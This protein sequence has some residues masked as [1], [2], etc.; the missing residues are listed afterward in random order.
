M[1][2][3]PKLLK[4]RQTHSRIFAIIVVALVLFCKPMIGYRSFWYQAMVWIGYAMVLVGAF[5]RVYC[6]VFIGGRKNDGIVRNGPF[7]VVRNPLYV[8]SFIA[9]VGCGLQSGMFSVV[10]LLVA[11]FALYYPQVVKKEEAF[12]SHKFGEEYEAYKREVPRW[13]PDMSKWQVPEVVESKPEFVLKTI[14]DALVFFVPLPCFMILH[15]LQ[16]Q[17]IFPIWLQLP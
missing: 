5:G 13:E 8:F 4:A 6:S 10:I 2:A 9:L 15:M 3:I 17:H 7:S 11:A 14:G 1:T 16:T 12:L